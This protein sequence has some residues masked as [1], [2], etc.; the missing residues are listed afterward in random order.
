MVEH[1]FRTATYEDLLGVPKT[2][3]A[4]ISYGQLVTHPRPS[5]RHAV[6]S[7]SENAVAL[8]TAQGQSTRLLLPT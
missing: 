4:E 8:L 7:S 1:A 5:P 2:L 6:A 3:V